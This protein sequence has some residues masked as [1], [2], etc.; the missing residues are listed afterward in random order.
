MGMRGM[1]QVENVSHLVCLPKQKQIEY[2]VYFA[3][4]C[5]MEQMSS[6]VIHRKCIYFGEVCVLERRF[7][8][9][10]FRHCLGARFFR[11]RAPV[12]VCISVCY[13][14]V[15]KIPDMCVY[16]ML[17]LP[18]KK[19]IFSICRTVFHHIKHAYAH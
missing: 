8:L 6:I 7:S 15:G 4:L 9:A 14:K 1:Q 16:V 17:E 19:H 13:R 3:A 18:G 5:C 12:T 11:Y 10:S 2:G